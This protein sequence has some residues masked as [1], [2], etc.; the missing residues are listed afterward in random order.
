MFKVDSKAMRKVGL[1]DDVAL[2]LQQRAAI[3]VILA[4]EGRFLV[5]LH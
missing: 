5:K 2:V 1:D 3:G 4:V